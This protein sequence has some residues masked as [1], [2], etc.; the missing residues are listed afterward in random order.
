MQ[1]SAAKI[2]EIKQATSKIANPAAML[3][4]Q[5]V[6]EFNAVFK[7]AA[8]AVANVNSNDLERKRAKDSG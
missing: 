8:A 7:E 5:M 2:N 4:P 1:N 6:E 3:K